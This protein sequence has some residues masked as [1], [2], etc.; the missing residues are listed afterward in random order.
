MAFVGQKVGCRNFKPG[1]VKQKDTSFKRNDLA[2]CQTV[3]PES[4]WDTGN[5]KF[6]T[7]KS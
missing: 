5:E 1:T 7:S 6:C 4:K 2:Y 3:R